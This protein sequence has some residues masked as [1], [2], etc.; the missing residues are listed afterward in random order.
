MAG[1]KL[2]A[3]TEANEEAHKL[4]L[5][6][7][8]ILGRRLESHRQELN[9]VRAEVLQLSEGLHAGMEKMSKGIQDLRDDIQEL[10]D[11]FKESNIQ[12]RGNKY[13]HST[14][15][16]MTAALSNFYESIDSI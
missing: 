1:H 11:I 12:E 15:S 3:A 14:A 10:T 4:E 8:K 7:E 16:Q 6:V 5:A 13:L 2:A 9:K